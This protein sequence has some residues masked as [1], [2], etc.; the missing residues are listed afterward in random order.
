MSAMHRRLPRKHRARPCAEQRKRYN[1][2]VKTGQT[3]AIVAIVL[4]ATLVIFLALRGRQPPV[5][6][7]DTDH[8]QFS[9]SGSCLSCHGP[10]GV[11]P[12]SRNHPL[13]PECMRCHGMP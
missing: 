13:G 7:A 6:P 10:D 2:R 4:L 11:H 12:Q 8:A 3:I 5:L 1:L 9:S